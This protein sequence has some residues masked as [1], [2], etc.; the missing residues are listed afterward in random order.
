MAMMGPGGVA[1][2][3]HHHHHQQQQQQQQQ[4]PFTLPPS[5]EL[6]PLYTLALVK[7]VAFRG[8]PDVRTDLRAFMIHLLS[9]MNV[10]TS[11]FFIYPRM[12]SI[13]DMAPEAG[14]PD[15]NGREEISPPPPNDG[16]GS[17]GSNSTT[18][19]QNKI[20]L[21]PIINLSMERFTSQSIFLLENG[22]AL[23]LWVGRLVDPTILSALFGV[24]SLDHIDPSTLKLQEKGSDLSSRLNNIIMAL[25]E[26]RQRYLQL[27][28]VVEGDPASLPFFYWNMVEDRAQFQ[29]GSFS[30]AE[31]MAMISRQ[32]YPP[33]GGPGPM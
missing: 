17:S 29:G 2:S 30:Y 12:F 31:Y 25:R 16:G 5:L 33:T 20:R 3:A 28:I 18:A 1:Y 8:G 21:P 23:Y 10:D 4:Q 11:R 7:N 22:I 24:H 14:T 19:G 9:V 32:G 6:L 13:H 26:E 27:S 15:S